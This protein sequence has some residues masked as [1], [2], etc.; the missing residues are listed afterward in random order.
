MVYGKLLVASGPLECRYSGNFG[1]STRNDWHVV[2]NLRMLK[3]GVLPATQFT[4]EAR[5]VFVAQITFQTD[6]Y[7]L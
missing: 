4:F 7:D 5:Q 3:L 1:A 2:D 6:Q